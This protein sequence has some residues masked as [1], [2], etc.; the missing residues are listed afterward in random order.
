MLFHQGMLPFHCACHDG[1]PRSVLEWLAEQHPTVVRT[2]TTD[3]HESPLHCYV[4][5]T[6]NVNGDSS[7]SA[8]QFL[9]EKYPDA[10]HSTNRKGSLPFHVA[11]VHNADLNVLFYLARQNPAALLLG[12]HDSTLLLP[13]VQIKRKRKRRRSTSHE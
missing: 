1:A 9:V 2:Y 13:K 10:L 8:I 11:A 3:T 5:S 4:S 6:N 7:F 12:C